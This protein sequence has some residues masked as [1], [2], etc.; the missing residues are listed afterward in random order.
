MH[1]ARVRLAPNAGSNDPLFVVSQESD[2][3][4]FVGSP[5][6]VRLSA[7]M[8]ESTRIRDLKLATAGWCRTDRVR[9]L[10]GYWGNEWAD[11]RRTRLTVKVV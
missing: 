8:S 2:S 7:R 9:F 11:R 4:V 10:C 3:Q 5:F 6:A 1:N